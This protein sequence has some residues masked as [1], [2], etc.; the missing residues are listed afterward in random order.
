MDYSYSPSSSSALE[1]ISISFYLFTL[2]ILLQ[3]V[4]TRLINA[5]NI[6]LVLRLADLFLLEFI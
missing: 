6:C 5:L 4:I 2:S 1:L 3:L